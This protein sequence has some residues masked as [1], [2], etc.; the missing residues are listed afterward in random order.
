[1][2]R[3]TMVRGALLVA[4]GLWVGLVPAALAQEVDV[5]VIYSRKKKEVKNQL[6]EVLA[7]KHTV[8]TYNADL[9]VV[10]DY[11]A[12]HKAVARFGR[13]QLVV[14]LPG[15]PMRALE[16]STIRAPLLVAKN[17]EETVKSEEWILYVVATDTDLTSMADV[18]E[19]LEVAAAG[20]LTDEAVRAATVVRVDEATI[21]VARVISL[22]TDQILKRT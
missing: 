5:Y 19:V 14:L 18:P 21:P 6:V 1:M 17:V 20:D 4:V 15:A 10:A 11:S 3:S 12:Q 7:Q 13:A 2:S 22:V 16:G 8:K 9:L